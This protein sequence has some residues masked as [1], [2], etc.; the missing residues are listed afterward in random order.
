MHLKLGEIFSSLQR[1]GW[2]IKKNQTNQPTIKN[3]NQ[4]SKNHQQK[5]QPKA[6][7]HFTRMID[8]ILNLYLLES[9]SHWEFIS[10]SL[11][12]LTHMK[13]P[14]TW[15]L[16]LK[17]LAVMT[18]EVVSPHPVILAVNFPAK[19]GLYVEYENICDIHFTL[20]FQSQSQELV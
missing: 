18:N 17:Y 1:I 9:I 7:K 2:T 20:V 13:F 8:I 4:T 6:P 11:N 15:F 12:L 14:L 16:G 3:P 5:K 10:S 19:Y